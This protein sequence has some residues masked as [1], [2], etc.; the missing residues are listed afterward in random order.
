MATKAQMKAVDSYRKRSVKQI[1]LRFYPKDEELYQ[2]G[3]RLGSTG[4]KRLIEEHKEA[5][6]K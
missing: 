6:Q 4:I 2:K 1:I 3:K 5:P